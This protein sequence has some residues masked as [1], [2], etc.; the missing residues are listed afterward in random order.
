[1]GLEHRGKG[2]KHLDGQSRSEVSKKKAKLIKERTCAGKGG[3]ADW[4]GREGRHPR[5][6]EFDSKE[7]G[8]RASKQAGKQASNQAWRGKGCALRVRQSSAKRVHRG[9][10]KC[11]MRALRRANGPAT[12][13]APTQRCPPCRHPA[14][15][16]EEIA[17]EGRAQARQFQPARANTEG[18]QTNASRKGSRGPNHNRAKAEKPRKRSRARRS[19]ARP[20]NEGRGDA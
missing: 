16:H 20:S 13:P 8:K 15:A 11:T 10:A 18:R 4:E 17:Q 19:E 1:M 14:R 9:A 3:E 2:E 12:A 7:A 5:T 6:S